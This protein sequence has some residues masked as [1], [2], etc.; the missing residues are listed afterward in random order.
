[1]TEA[2]E[3]GVPAS[4]R[5]LVADI[6]DG[7]ASALGPELQGIY[8]FG[9]LV[10]GDFDERVSDVDLLAITR[11]DLDGD[12]LANL[13]TL[14]HRLVQ[15][16]PSWEDRIE[17]AYLSA[18]ALRTFKTARSPIAVISPGEPFHVKDAGRDWLLNWFIVQE[19]SLAL[20]GPPAQTLVPTITI[21]EVREE[22]NI[23]LEAWRARVKTS[24]HPGFLAYA[25]LTACR[26]WDTYEK[27]VIRSKR[28]SAAW[29]KL[30]MPRWSPLID[31]ALHVRSQGGQVGPLDSNDA[32]AF[33]SDVAHQVC[34]PRPTQPAEV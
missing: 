14:H 9:S 28:E 24:T 1:M 19:H 32:A 16:H 30:Q 8:L 18:R 11:T 6:T 26:A 7:V 2:K 20:V 4:V 17:I 5:R 3:A 27:G 29:V 23:Q 33:V 10:T 31:Q 12:Q 21:D 13:A 25:V 15:T 22:I 34:S